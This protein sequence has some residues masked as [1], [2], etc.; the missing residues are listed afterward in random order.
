MRVYR[1]VRRQRYVAKT[2]S[3]NR[4]MRDHDR[5]HH[6]FQLLANNLDQVRGRQG[7]KG[8]SIGPTHSSKLRQLLQS[9][10]EISFNIGNFA[11]HIFLLF[12]WTWN[13]IY[14]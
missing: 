2:V 10:R 6:R 7:R 12:G 3:F 1:I 13:L 9:K 4:E 14:L 8:H 11:R 5:G